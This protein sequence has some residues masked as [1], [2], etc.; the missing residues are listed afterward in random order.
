MIHLFIT[1]LFLHLSLGEGDDMS[2]DRYTSVVT[3]D[4]TWVTSAHGGANPR[5]NGAIHFTSNDQY[6]V[7]TYAQ[8]AST[9]P[10]AL[11]EC[12]EGISITF[13]IKLAPSSITSG[14]TSFLRISESVAIHRAHPDDQLH[15]IVKTETS[16]WFNTVPPNNGWTHIGFTWTLQEGATV[17]C[18]G[19]PW[20]R[21]ETPDDFS[22]VQ[23][24]ADIQLSK[25]HRADPPFAMDE[26][27]VWT[28]AKPMAFMEIMSQMETD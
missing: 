13:W 21:D 15:F 20:Q 22:G 23:P 10:F 14:F 4:V 27:F 25:A 28:K 8:S 16:M 19:V 18:D 1:D 5:P 2:T 12:S 7:T 11:Q 17:F 26:L 6:L 3:G 9:C 24:T